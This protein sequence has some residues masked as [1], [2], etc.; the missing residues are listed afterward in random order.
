MVKYS[1]SKEIHLLKLAVQLEWNKTSQCTIKELVSGPIKWPKIISLSKLMGVQTFIYELLKKNNLEDCLPQNYFML[2]Q[3]AYHRQG[4]ETL[5]LKRQIQEIKE[6]FTQKKIAFCLIKGAELIDTIYIHSPIRPM[7]DIDILCHREDIKA[8]QQVLTNL[9]Y[10]QKTMHQSHELASLSTHQKHFPPFFH[11]KRHT[12]EIHFNLFSGLPLDEIQTKDVWK[13]A[14][15]VKGY[16]QFNLTKEHHLLFMC[17]HLAYHILSPHEGLVLYWFCDISEWIKK[18]HDQIDWSFFSKLESMEIKERAFSILKLI[19]KEWNPPLPTNFFQDYKNIKELSLDNI[20]KKITGEDALTKKRRIFTYY[21]NI[22]FNKNPQWS[23]RT[24][25]I[26]WFRLL[27]P[28]A[29][30]LKD[31]YQIKNRMLLTI[32][33]VFHPFIILFRAIKRL[34]N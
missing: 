9:G 8:I 32:L 18:Y 22:W 20:L 1:L 23:L 31:R 33:L 19:Q 15:P 30:Y 13:T 21:Y 5:F 34:I 26:H 12:I 29:P 10:K 3:S 4:M 11:E 25:L 2:L 24:R 17:N 6:V 7:S 27:F 28:Q 16:S 14:I